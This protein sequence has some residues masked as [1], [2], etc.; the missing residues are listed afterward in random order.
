[1]TCFTQWDMTESMAWNFWEVSLKIEEVGRSV[2]LFFLF[3]IYNLDMTVVA[4][5]GILCPWEWEP[6]AKDSCVE[7]RNLSPWWPC[8]TQPPLDH[9]TQYLSLKVKKK[10]NSVLFKPLLLLFSVKLI[11]VPKWYGEMGLYQFLR[12]TRLSERYGKIF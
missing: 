9:L 6:S 1:M 12:D 8:A 3:L 4:P 5:E 10:Y 2:L 7:R 11:A